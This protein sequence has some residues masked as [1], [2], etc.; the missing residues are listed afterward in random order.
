[1]DDKENEDFARFC[2]VLFLW[3]AGVLAFAMAV[4]V[5]AGIVTKVARTVSG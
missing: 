4:G 5:F 1:M 2:M 3:I